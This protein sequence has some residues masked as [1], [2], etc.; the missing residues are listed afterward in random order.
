MIAEA[1]SFALARGGWTTARHHSVP[2]TDLPLSALPG[3]LAIF[4]A[5]MARSVAPLAAASYARCSGGQ[6]R[7][8]GA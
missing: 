5:A 7:V 3:A 6:L 1:G 2:T 4:N 8:H